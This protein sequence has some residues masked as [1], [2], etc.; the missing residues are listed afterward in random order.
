MKKEPHHIGVVDFYLRR[1]FPLTIISAPAGKKTDGRMPPSTIGRNRAKRIARSTVAVGAALL[2]LATWSHAAE[3]PGA[4]PNPRPYVAAATIS[5]FGLPLASHA[6]TDPAEFTMAKSP[7]SPAVPGAA[8][9]T[10]VVLWDE[11][12]RPKGTRPPRRHP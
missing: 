4:F 12:M 6:A 5:V 1:Q 9:E 7:P 10:A 8:I 2:P 3:R 11:V